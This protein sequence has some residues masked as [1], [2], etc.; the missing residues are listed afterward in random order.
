MSSAEEDL[1]SEG[2]ISAEEN[3]GQLE[4]QTAESPP[5][6]PPPVARVRDKLLQGLMTQRSEA[7]MNASHRNIRSTS[8][9]F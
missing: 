4:A 7:R 1:A 5:D 8:P 6:S 9:E 2:L 3:A